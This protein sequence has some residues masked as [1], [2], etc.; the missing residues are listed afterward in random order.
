M[1][2]RRA[3]KTQSEFKASGVGVIVTIGYP[4]TVAAKTA[5]IPTVAAAGVGDP[6]ATGLVKGP[7]SARWHRYRISD[8]AT[9]LPTKRLSLQGIVTPPAPGSDAVECGRSGH[10]TAL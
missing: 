6:V 2:A 9:T 1:P 4:A 8:N 3:E 7:R 5:G 10:V